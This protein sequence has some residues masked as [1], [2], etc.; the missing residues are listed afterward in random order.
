MT[1]VIQFFLA[2]G[3]AVVHFGLS[4]KGAIRIFL[5]GVV[6]TGITMTRATLPRIQLSDL[7]T[8]GWPRVRIDTPTNFLYTIE[9]SSTLTNWAPVAV[10]HGREFITNPPSLS[11]IDANGG[12]SGT[13]FYRMRLE[14][15]EFDDDW[16]NQVYFDEDTFRNEPISFGLPETR[17]IKFAITTNEPTRVYYQNSWKYPFHYNFA[18]ARL[19]EFRGLTPIQFDEVSLHTNSQ[20]I[21]LGAVLFSPRPEDREVGIQFVGQDPYTPEQV[22]EWFEVVRTTIQPIGEVNVRYIPTFEQAGVAATNAAFFASR[23]IEIGSLTDWDTGAN[24]YSHGW[25]RR[26]SAMTLF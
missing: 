25:A 1:T 14:P 3:K 10:L 19:P 21:V 2:R 5:L 23:G 6:V 15:I 13:R 24:A 18:S 7:D 26:L 12:R 16:R 22:A 17:W 8:N 9:I 11:F 4:M 20:R